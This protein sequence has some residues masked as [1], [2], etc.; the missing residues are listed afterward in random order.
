[1]KLCITRYGNK[2]DSPSL[3]EKSPIVRYSK[4]QVSYKEL[5]YLASLSQDNLQPIVCVGTV[6]RLVNSTRRIT[7]NIQQMVFDVNGH[8]T[9]QEQNRTEEDRKEWVGKERINPEG[10]ALKNYVLGL[11][12]DMTT[13]KQT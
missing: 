6:S 13:M 2:A 10:N 4:A 9:D 5:C 1:M 11:W 8:I 3:V 12:H 7:L